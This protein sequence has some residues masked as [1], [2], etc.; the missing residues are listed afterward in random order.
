MHKSQG[1][2]FD[3]VVLILKDIT[4]FISREL[5]YTALTRAREKLYLVVHK[6]IAENLPKL[7]LNVSYNSATENIRTMLFIPK[8]SITKPYLLKIKNGLTIALRSKIEYII[9]KILDN[10]GIDFEYEPN[11][12]AS[13]SI[14]PD[15]KLRI[16]GEV[17]YWEHLGRLDDPQY[18][19]R[20]KKKLEFYRKNGLDERLITTSESTEASDWEKSV[21]Q[22]IEDLRGQKLKETPNGYPSKHH[23]EI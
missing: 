2:D 17:Y 4:S 6:D 14:R 22:I 10:L 15:F 7:L 13:E 21:K 1:S 9:A 3:N 23:Y 5:I 19:E 11:D 8:K 16:N 18:R 12:F 20:W